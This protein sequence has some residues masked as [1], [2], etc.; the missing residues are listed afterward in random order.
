ME[1]SLIKFSFN[2]RHLTEPIIVHDSPRLLV[3]TYVVCERLSVI[4]QQV[5][6]VDFL[7][8][9]LSLSVT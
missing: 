8:V 7:S 3:S 2:F 9:T 1:Y 6:L 5:C 4:Q